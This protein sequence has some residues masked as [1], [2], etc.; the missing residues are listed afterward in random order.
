MSFSA[1][2]YK[3]LLYRLMPKGPVWPVDSEATPVWDSLLTALSKEFARVG[4]VI[5]SIPDAIIPSAT[6]RSEGLDKWEEI[7]D[8]SPESTAS[9]ADRRTAI[10]AKLGEYIGPSLAEI[11]AYADLFGVGAVVTHHEYPRFTVDQSAVGDAVNGLQFLVT[12]TVTYDGP[13][14]DTF[15]AAMRVVQPAHTTLLFVVV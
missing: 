10:L 9:D 1:D 6:M 7:L 12:W 8:L 4:A 5:F 13:Q 14:S 2:D 15:E 11:Q 3:D